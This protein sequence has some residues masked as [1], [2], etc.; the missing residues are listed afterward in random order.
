MTTDLR[1]PSPRTAALAVQISEAE[2]RLRNR[3]RLVRV[4]GA[5]LGRTLHQRMTAPAM[6]LLAGGLG[7][8][9]GELTR[10]Q[11]P[12][13]RGM[14]RSPDSGHP[15]FETALNLIQLVTWARAL[16]TALPGAGR[17]PSSPLEEPVQTTDRSQENSK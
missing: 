17:Q 15:F 1:N 2:R 16:F 7:F 12:Q 13:S 10:R 9:M 5:T 3:R 4:R 14:D 6:L 11:T 8:L